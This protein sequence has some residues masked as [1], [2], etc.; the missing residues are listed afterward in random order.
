MSLNAR[1]PPSG[2]QKRKAKNIRLAETNKLRGSLDKFCKIAKTT[3]VN[4][5][6]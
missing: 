6:R 1:R 5:G 3:H 4:T 2:C